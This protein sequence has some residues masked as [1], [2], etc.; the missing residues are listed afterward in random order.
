MGINPNK[1]KKSAKFLRIVM[2]VTFWA[3][4]VIGTVLTIAFFVIAFAPGDI[5]KLPKSG[6]MTI[7]LLYND[8]ISYKVDSSMYDAVKLKSILLT[9]IPAILLGASMLAIIIRQVIN[10]LRSVENDCPF[11]EKNSNRLSKIGTVM[12]V[13]SSVFNIAQYSI[14]KAVITNF[15]ITNIEA[16]YAF[17]GT[18]LITGFLILILAG[19]FKYGNFLQKEYDAT[20]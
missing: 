19:V 13:G 1:V 3:T 17:D 14:A 12:I 20:L 10:I 16:R 8:I 5:I 2:S 6:S 11:E 18:M 9:S 15:Q 4:I 7:S